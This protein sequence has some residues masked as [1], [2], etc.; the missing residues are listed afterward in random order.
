ME[1]IIVKNDQGKVVPL[2]HD[3]ITSVIFTALKDSGSTD[4]LLAL[5]IADKVMYRLELLKKVDN[6]FFLNELEQMIRFVLNEVGYPDA[7]RQINSLSEKMI[8]FS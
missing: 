3:D 7:A 2:E 8:I 4:R 6:R 1:Y 5:N